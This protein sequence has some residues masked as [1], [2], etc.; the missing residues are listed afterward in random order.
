ME[1][2]QFY[3]AYKEIDCGYYF[4]KLKNIWKNK[5]ICIICGESVFNK[6][7]FNIFETA[8]SIEYCYAPAKNAFECYDNILNNSLKID[9]KR[10]IIGILGP[11]SCVL[12]LDLFL[13]GYRFLDLGH[14]AKSYDWYSRKIFSLDKK[15]LTEFFDPD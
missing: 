13:A 9:K 1:I 8:N 4:D 5:D 14:I 7:R 11:T 3:A 12:G 15:A 6:I 10:I 2:S